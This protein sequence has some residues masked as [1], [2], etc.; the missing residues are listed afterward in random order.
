MKLLAPAEAQDKAKSK[1][2]AHKHRLVSLEGLIQQKNKELADAEATFALTLK[3][4][5]DVWYT[6]EEKHKTNILSLRKEVEGL[7]ERRRQALIPLTERAKILDTKASA[8]DEREVKLNKFEEG[9]LQEADQLVNRLDE[10]SE[11]ELQADKTAKTLAI[12][13]EGIKAQAAQVAAG[14]ASLTGAIAQA[15][16]ESNK[17]EEA[18]V[19]RE[20]AVKGKEANIAERERKVNE[21]EAGFDNREKAIK[22]QYEA[23]RQAI[24]EI[25]KKHGTKQKLQRDTI[26]S[27]SDARDSG[28]SL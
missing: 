1:A 26:F 7:E 11:R 3:G 27:N 25:N 16:A 6:E 22:D 20:F 19:L 24:E 14:S 9:L 8:L 2:E 23:L 4:Q 10:V 18:L 21:K 28:G 5:R 17:R 15:T 13:E 12:Q